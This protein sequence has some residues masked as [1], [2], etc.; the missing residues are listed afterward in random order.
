MRSPSAREQLRNVVIQHEHYNDHQ[1]HHADFEHGFLH[2]HTHITP[3]HHLDE[4]QQDK[5]AVE[6]RD[7]QE[8]EDR[9][10][11]TYH[12]HQSDKRGGTL[13]RRIS[14]QAR[15]PYG[16]LDGFGRHSALNQTLQK[17]IN[18]RSALDVLIDGLA[19]SLAET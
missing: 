2:L 16:T 5:S 9:E 3:H 14:R 7:R 6:N 10:I 18:Q 8:I 13:P 19:Q 17:L 1:E 11:Q 4:Q 12:R 15:N